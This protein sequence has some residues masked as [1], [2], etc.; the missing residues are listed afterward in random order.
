MSSFCFSLLASIRGSDER[1]RPR[2]LT[3]L[4]SQNTSNLSKTI[5]IPNEDT[6][7]PRTEPK[8]SDVRQSFADRKDKAVSKS[9]G[10]RLQ[11]KLECMRVRMSPSSVQLR[12]RVQ[13]QA[14]LTESEQG[15]ERKRL[16][17]AQRSLTGYITPNCSSSKR[18]TPSRDS[19]CSR[20][21]SR[22]PI[23]QTRP[24]RVRRGNEKKVCETRKLELEL[25][26]LL[27]AGGRHGIGRAL[28]TAPDDAGGY[29][30]EH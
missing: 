20:E 1:S 11:L 6:A 21:A 9:N 2:R 5:T 3:N 29:G 24:G 25:S 14:E 7:E 19:L 23:E 18:P 8:E 30:G 16:K 13:R 28:A 15:N 26:L 27:T 22:M 17:R 4:S 10:V 12:M